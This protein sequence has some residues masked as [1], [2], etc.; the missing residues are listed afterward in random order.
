MS[1]LGDQTLFFMAALS[2]GKKLQL[3]WPGRIQPLHEPAKNRGDISRID[4]AT[5]SPEESTE[6]GPSVTSSALHWS[7]SPS[8]RVHIPPGEPQMRA[9]A[10]GFVKDLSSRL[11][12]E[13]CLQETSGQALREALDQPG[14]IVLQLAAHRPDLRL[15]LDKHHAARVLEGEPE[16]PGQETGEGGSQDAFLL[17]S[18]PE[19]A[20]TLVAD[21]AQTLQEAC[22][23]VLETVAPLPHTGRALGCDA[24]TL[25]LPSL[26][27]LSVSRK[28]FR[29]VAVAASTQ[30]QCPSGFIAA[31]SLA[32]SHQPSMSRSIRFARHYVRSDGRCVLAP[33]PCGLATLVRLTDAAERGAHAGLALVQP[34]IASGQRQQARF[35]RA[36]HSRRVWVPCSQLREVPLLN[37]TG[38]PWREATYAEEAG[39]GGGGVT[40]L[41]FPPG[42]GERSGRA[43]VLKRTQEPVCEVAATR[44]ARLLGVRRPECVVLST[45]YANGAPL[46]GQC[47]VT[48]LLCSRGRTA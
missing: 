16:V 48:V 28:Q 25:A 20:L 13:L 27:L 29:R 39:S 22:T 35:W 1:R 8:S 12:R 18:G 4:V 21:T 42:S 11:C 44:L 26:Y 9:V 10:E 14:E 15:V 32:W 47:G 19:G 34:L 46:V 45:R 36:F 24:P 7:F 3:D 37:P 33:L 17:C 5:L 30:L 2:P 31:A 38:I 43:L 40:F 6:G 23:L 41:E